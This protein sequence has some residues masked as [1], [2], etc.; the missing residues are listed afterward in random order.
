MNG[1]IGMGFVDAPRDSG[2]ELLSLYKGRRSVFLAF[3]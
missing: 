2:R 3:D 1:G